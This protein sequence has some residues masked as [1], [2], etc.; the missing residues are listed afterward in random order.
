MRRR[1]DRRTRST[2]AGTDERDAQLLL[3]LSWAGDDRF[4]GNLAC[5]GG[6]PDGACADRSEDGLERHRREA[7]P[8]R[9]ARAV[10]ARAGRR[11]E[12]GARPTTPVVA[13][14]QLR[15]DPLDTDALVSLAL[16]Q[17]WHRLAEQV[18]AEVG[19]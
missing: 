4:S 19:P 9:A 13:V 5:P 11:V 14:R 12:E 2:S 8:G 10:L 7:G 6:A 18:E 15:G 17:D 16:A 1:A 3:T